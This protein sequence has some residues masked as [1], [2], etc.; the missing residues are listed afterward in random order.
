MTSPAQA[1][2]GARTQLIDQAVYLAL[3]RHYPGKKTA[4]RPR[5]PTRWV[6]ERKVPPSFYG[7]VLFAWDQITSRREAA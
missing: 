5:S 7:A 1:R 2:D 3:K 4:F 6:R